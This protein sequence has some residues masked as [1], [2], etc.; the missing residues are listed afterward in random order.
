[1]WQQVCR[2][3]LGGAALMRAQHRL[4]MAVRV[5]RSMSAVHCGPLP[6]ASVL[7]AYALQV[8]L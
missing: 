8:T 6:A 1:M 4:V 2:G 5:S 3:V 7:A